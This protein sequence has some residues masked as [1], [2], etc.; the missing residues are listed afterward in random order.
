MIKIFV[1]S[2]GTGGTARRALNAALT[3]FEGANPEII[4]RPNIRCEEE[5]ESV[6]REAVTAKGFIVHTLVS[7]EAREAMIRSGRLYNIATCDLMGP[8]LERLSQQL[9]ITPSMKPGLFRQLN[10]A[11][12]RRV[13]TMEYAFHHDDGLRPE[14]I[15]SAE[16]ILIGISRTF[17]T[18]LSI[19]LA[20]K[21]WFVA[22]VPIVLDLP[23]PKILFELPEGKVIGL[24]ANPYRLAELRRVREEHLS[25]ATGSYARPEYVRR[26]MEY[27]LN[28][29]SEHPRWPIV[30]VTAKPIEEIASEILS[31]SSQKLKHHRT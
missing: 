9:S 7:N 26:E 4:E 12:F 6:V 21:G 22:N 30:D 23:L 3:Q 11:Y 5:V 14:E 31:F 13:E 28:I 15:A 8:L 19:Y 27:A 24:R 29:F 25:G 17:K 16:I 18:P 1:V 2:D 20:F 10:K